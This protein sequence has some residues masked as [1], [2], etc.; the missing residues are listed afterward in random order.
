MQGAGSGAGAGGDAITGSDEDRRRIEFRAGLSVAAAAAVVVLS[1]V[2]QLVL[3]DERASWPLTA[4]AAAAFLAAA[5]ATL[6][7]TGWWIDSVRAW[8]GPHEWPH[9]RRS[10]ASWLI[11]V[12]NLAAP[13][14]EAGLLFRSAGRPE[15]WS[16][17]WTGLWLVA[18]L[19]SVVRPLGWKV[20]GV[21]DAWSF[22]RL[23]P[24]A[25]VL[26]LVVSSMRSLR[27]EWGR[28]DD[29]GLPPAGLPPTELTVD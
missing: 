2:A 26:W 9:R 10:V 25:L 3:A 23:V 6:G 22:A 27:A 12:V 29:T 19:C 5:V 11:P 15:R 18:V 16:K 24:P 28:R 8:W 14:I 13:P 17:W 7:F 21:V 20:W 4:S 1:P